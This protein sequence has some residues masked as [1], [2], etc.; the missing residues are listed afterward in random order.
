MR[1]VSLLAGFLRSSVF[2][3]WRPLVH[4]APVA[5]SHSGLP[6]ARCESTQPSATIDWY[7]CDAAVT[8]K[9]PVRT[10]IV[11]LLPPSDAIAFA[12]FVW[13]SESVISG[14]H[15]GGHSAGLHGLG[16]P[17]SGSPSWWLTTR[18]SGPSLERRSTRYALRKLPARTVSFCFVTRR[19]VSTSSRSVDGML[20]HTMLYL[21]CFTHG[22]A[23]RRSYVRGAISSSATTCGHFAACSCWPSKAM[24]SSPWQSSGAFGQ[25][26]PWRMFIVTM[27]R[28]A[29]GAT[30]GELPAPADAAGAASATRTP[31]TSTT[32]S[33]R[34]E[35]PYFCRSPSQAPAPAATV[36]KAAVARDAGPYYALT[37]V[38]GN[39][40]RALPGA[41]RA[42]VYR[43]PRDIVVEERPVPELGPDDVLLE[44]SHCGVCGSDLHMFVDGWGA[45]N[46]IGGHEFSGRVVAVGHGVTAWSAGDEVVGGPSQRCGECEYC[47]A[48]RPQLCIGRSNPGVGEFQ[49]AFADFVRV[50][51]PELLRVPPGVSMR[52]A[53]LTEPLAVALHG[54]TRGGVGAG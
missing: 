54:L 52:A 1:S 44:V 22:A 27:R 3:S 21:H 6:A 8:L 39:A 47:L 7:R 35:F 53:A 43:G 23:A 46:S 17:G 33:F 9:S 48:G 5:G 19:V 4:S 15:S 25:V 10:R 28:S 51:E 36:G 12:W 20:C 34:T 41:M 45:P 32:S 14:G 16:S 42:A 30:R 2:M 49:G 18:T 11:L 50:R 29:F 26:I 31:T 40:T 38:S 37:P 24:R 13:Q